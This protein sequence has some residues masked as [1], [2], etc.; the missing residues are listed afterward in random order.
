M[1]FTMIINEL[2]YIEYVG[3]RNAVIRYNSSKKVWD[4]S[5]IPHPEVAAR[6]KAVFG[7]LLIGKH[8]WQISDDTQCQPGVV[9]LNI[10]LSTCSEGQFTCGDGECIDIDFRCDRA[11]HCRDWSDEIDCNIVQTPEGYL[12]E[13]VPINLEKDLS[14]KKV[15]A[16]KKSRQ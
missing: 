9:D 7:T 14:I 3:L 11:K 12:K 5:S 1:K 6:S 10:K 2:G 4:I 13:F 15:V 8:L 16:I